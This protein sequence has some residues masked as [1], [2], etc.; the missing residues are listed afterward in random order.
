MKKI[1][2]NGI[3]VFPGETLPCDLLIEN[4][5][6][7]AVGKD[8]CRDGAEVIDA[9]GKCVLP[10]AVDVH[11]HMDLDVGIA[12]A[13]DNFYDGT[14]AA[15]CGGTT[16]IVD[17]LAF[18]PKGCALRH[19]IDEYHQLADGKAVIDYGFH[20]VL[21]HVDEQVL[22][23][24]GTLFHEGYTSFK[25]YMTYDN[26]LNDA[27]IFQV[28]KRAKELGMVIPVHAE[29]DGVVNY[30][31]AWYKAQGLCT[32]AYHPKSRPDGTEAEAVSRILH[33][34]A[35]AGDA[36]VYIVHLSTGKG[37][38]EIQKARAGGQKNIIVET[39]PQYLTLTDEK[40]QDEKEG[41]KYIMSPPLRKKEDNEALWKAAADGD[42]Q[43][44]AT[45]HCPFTFK[46]QK[47][48]GAGDF[49]A[50][51]NGAPG[52]EERVP[53]LFSEGVLKNRISINKFVELLCENPAKAYGLY[54]QKGTLLP[55]SDADVVLIDPAKERTLTIGGLHGACDYCTYEGMKLQ[56]N[57][58]MVFSHGDLIVKDNRF[59]G[60]KGAGRFLKRGKSLLIDESGRRD[61]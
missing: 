29:N 36:P 20:G 17:H 47:Q 41:L 16:T 8:L 34:A 43:V 11:T 51:P 27:E 24:M 60:K 6:I 30:L 49:T 19:Q 45:D 26:K 56:G 7:A 33:L 15:A 12:R 55:G 57:I 22:A 35:M 5:K 50:C 38:K 31:R 61:S 18:G 54:P 13:V 52:V 42:I 59:L 58:E 32:P 3:V 23:D 9:A 1:I 39:C 21:Q 28:L 37:L 44:I 48:R 40:Y 25:V 53:L 2:A 14:V 10:G 46:T 4:G